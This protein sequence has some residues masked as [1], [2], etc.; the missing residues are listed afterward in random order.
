MKARYMLSVYHSKEG[1][2]ALL[3]R[4]AEV[5]FFPREGDQFII[6]GV[7]VYR[8]WG[9]EWDADAN[10]A[11]VWLDDSVYED[12]SEF[13]EEV[14]RL[15]GNGWEYDGGEFGDKAVREWLD[16]VIAERYPEMMLAREARH[17]LHWQQFCDEST[18]ES[19]Q[20]TEAQ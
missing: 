4:H 11:V 7:Q 19:P 5:P 16:E 9:S 1:D 10:V 14:L 3:F 17:Q 2:N 12:R 6:A 15:L 8:C 20:L 18:A 13:A